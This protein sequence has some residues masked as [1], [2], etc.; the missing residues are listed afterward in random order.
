MLSDGEMDTDKGRMHVCVWVMSQCCLSFAAHL[1]TPKRDYRT[2]D[3]IGAV[4]DR[5]MVIALS[6]L[7]VCILLYML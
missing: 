6:S 4:R 2:Y 5:V 3:G 1:S 7:P